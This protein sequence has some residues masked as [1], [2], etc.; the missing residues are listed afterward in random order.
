MESG[1]IGD[2]RP[3]LASGPRTRASVDSAPF[4][5]LPPQQPSPAPSR[6]SFP[7]E[8]QCSLEPQFPSSRRSFPRAAVFPPAAVSTRASR[9]TWRP[10]PLAPRIGKHFKKRRQI[11]Q[12]LQKSSY[13]TCKDR[14]PAG[15]ISSW[16]GEA[17]RAIC[18]QV[19]EHPTVVFLVRAPGVSL[20]R[21]GL[22][23][24]LAPW[25][26]GVHPGP[27]TEKDQREDHLSL[28]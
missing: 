21:S 25:I 16:Y 11:S 10:P 2:T 4:A 26:P 22:R 3:T 1:V 13:V 15:N 23:S 24:S 19:Q 9:R 18:D 7:L 20:N 28:L 14:L 8:R 6:L 17:P 12:D 5:V 27:Q